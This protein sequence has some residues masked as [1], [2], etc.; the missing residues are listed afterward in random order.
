ME[1]AEQVAVRLVLLWRKT[2]LLAVV[3][4]PRIPSF[5]SIH[6]ET[7]SQMLALLIPLV[8]AVPVAVEQEEE[9]EEVE[10][11]AAAVVRLEEMV[12]EA[13]ALAAQV[14]QAQ[15]EAA[16]LLVVLVSL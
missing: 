16:A 9:A 6:S 10:W 5:T 7:E 3:R 2:H 4:C 1:E 14:E 8:Q 11:E 12:T 13:E 15:E